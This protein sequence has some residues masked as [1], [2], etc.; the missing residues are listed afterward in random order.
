MNISANRFGNDEV[1]RNLK[2]DQFAKIINKYADL[3]E[4]KVRS[5]KIHSPFDIVLAQ[6]EV[7]DD[8][9]QV[10]GFTEN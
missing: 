1:P 10:F 8:I 2:R 7:A 4:I 3:M 6:A 9:Y 5:V